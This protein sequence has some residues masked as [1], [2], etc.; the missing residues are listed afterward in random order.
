[1]GT[2]NNREHRSTSRMAARTVFVVAI[3]AIIALTYTSV[4]QA[5]QCDCDCLFKECEK[6]KHPGPY[7]MT[8]SE[9]R[10]KCQTCGTDQCNDIV[11]LCI[12]TEPTAERKRKCIDGWVK[13]SNCMC[14]YTACK[15]YV[16]ATGQE[17]RCHEGLALCRNC[18]TTQCKLESDACLKKEGIHGNIN[19]C[20]T[21]WYKCAKCYCSYKDCKAHAPEPEK[22][23]IGLDLCRR[24]ETEKCD[25]IKVACLR[26]SKDQQ[27][28]VKDWY[29]CVLAG[30]HSY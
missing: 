15:K 7:N 22:C 29:T 4:A 14:Q 18:D 12:S 1:M 2:A 24:C 5:A 6:R 21:A 30:C 28:C 16:Q 20:I 27:K 11:F 13:C 25:A 8:C 23:N 17:D 19:K 26:A 9:I 3:V 10:Q